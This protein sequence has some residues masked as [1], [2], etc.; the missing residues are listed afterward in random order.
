MKKITIRGIE[1]PFRVTVG[2]MVAYKRETGE[3]VSYFKG[4]DMEKL[5]VLLFH[6]LRSSCRACS[7]D[8]PFSSEDE[9]LD[10]IDIKDASSLLDI[11][12][13]GPSAVA[14]EKKS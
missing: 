9:L 3:D 4:D 14:G 13:G 10:Y 6:S 2:A 11:G 5:G 12:V 8:F 1:Y 7:I